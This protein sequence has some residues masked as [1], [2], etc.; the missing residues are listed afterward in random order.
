MTR[1]FDIF[2][3]LL[4]LLVLSPILALL[5]FWI[6]LDS[7]GGV[8][9]KQTRVGKHGK[10]FQ[11]LKLR[12]MRIDAEKS[13]Q[14]TVGARDP[15]IT[16][17]GLFIRKYKLD[18]MPQLIN[19]LKGEMSLVGPRPEVP[20]YVAL[21]NEKQLRILNVKPGITDV[22]SLAYFHENELLAA[23]ENPEQTYIDEVMPAK[24]ELNLAYINNPSL[25]A[26]FS[27]VFK[28]IA[29]ILK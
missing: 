7:K 23:S 1:F 20:K 6:L 4:G 27:V 19:V 10:H 12:S 21:Y 22:A 29:K 16:N 5:A 25:A 24:L 18:E 17:S 14:L 8:F 3:S 26:Y 13:G 2:L 11:L 15:R 9:F 28:T